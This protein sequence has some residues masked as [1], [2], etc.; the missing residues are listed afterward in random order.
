MKGLIFTYLLCYGGSVV[1]LFNP[2]VGLLVYV[3]FAILKPEALW[4]WS[5]AG[6][7]SFS[8]TIAVALLLGWALQGFGN[9]RLRNAGG[10]VVAFVGLWSWSVLS[11][12]GA[13]DPGVAWNFVEGMAK[14]LLPFLAG[15]TLIRSPNQLRQLIWTIVLCQGYLAFE[16]NRSYY[17]GFNVV[18]TL[19]FAGLDNNSVS[20]GMVTGAGLAF[21]LGTA[22]DVWWQKLVAF[23]SSLLM[24]H[25]VL[26][27]F[28]RGGMLA[29]LVLGIVSFALIPWRPRHLAVL[30]FAA[31]LAVRLAGPE[32]RERFATAFVEGEE[33]DFAAQSR[34]DLWANCWDVM[35][36]NPMIGIGPDH[37][38]LVAPEY[39]WPLGKEAHTLW[40]QL[41][42]ELGFPGL[43][44]IVL[45]YGLCVVRLWPLARGSTQT[46]DPWARDTARM[47]IAGLSGFAVAAQFV[48]LEGLETPYYVVLVGAGVLK[49]VSASET[50]SPAR[51]PAGETP[52]YNGLWLKWHSHA[53]AGRRL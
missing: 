1:A 35:L 53:T 49:L 21:F 17:S 36:K 27:A 16:F 46:E 20:I 42:A 34:L 4:E 44:F 41:G 40:L 38:P 18:T 26:F 12:I 31:L 25:V 52:L 37:F 47:V 24:C 3:V 23:G 8:R 15:V 29:L 28:S 9:W 33:R 2:F 11:A 45:F 7:G 13:R 51:A 14:V 43:F 39:G 10:I 19:G 22:T 50:T 32:V 30:A 6:A 48:S 5:F